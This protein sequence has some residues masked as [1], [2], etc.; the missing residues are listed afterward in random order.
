MVDNDEVTNG[1]KVR[2]IIVFLKIQEFFGFWVAD[3]ALVADTTDAL[4]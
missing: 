3:S 2:S 4:F 1:F